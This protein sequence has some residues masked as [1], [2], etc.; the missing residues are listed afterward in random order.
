MLLN[1]I[2]DDGFDKLRIEIVKKEQNISEQISN[3][4]QIFVKSFYL[5][6]YSFKLMRGNLSSFLLYGS[7]RLKDL[8][9]NLKE[10]LI[11]QS[12]QDI[13]VKFICEKF[14]KEFQS[15]NNFQ[16]ISIVKVKK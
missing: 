10:P 3:L 2:Q 6:N 7:E 8:I 4:K 9:I 15:L 13:V 11:D 1:K 5:S 14:K 16:Q 12:Q